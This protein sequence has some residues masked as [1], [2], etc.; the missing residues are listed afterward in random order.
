ML[1]VLRYCQQV[2]ETAQHCQTVHTFSVAAKKQASCLSSLVIYNV[3]G[4]RLENKATPMWF[5]CNT[6]SAYIMQ[7]FYSVMQLTFLK[8]S[9]DF[10]FSDI[11]TVSQKVIDKVLVI[12]WLSRWWW[13]WTHNFIKYWPI[14]KIIS[15]RILLE[16]YNN[17][18]T[19]CPI[20]PQTCCYTT[21]CNVNVRKLAKVTNQCTYHIKYLH[22]KM[23]FNKK[24]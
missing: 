16:V 2:I 1:C 12:R 20:I 15:L 22:K 11:Y 7:A 4:L 23:K 18:V 19:K 6:R 21:L 24:I 14:F 13:W 9:M 3:Y 17:A 10:Y 5:R 8:K